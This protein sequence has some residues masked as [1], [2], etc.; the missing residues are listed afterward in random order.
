MARA[1]LSVPARTA[2]ADRIF[3]GRSVLDYGCGRGG[4]VRRLAAEQLDVR[5]WDPH[6]QPDPP[7]TLADVVLLSYVLNV[8]D[9][10][11]ERVRTLAAAWELARVCLVVA[12]RTHHDARKLRGIA[13]RDGLLTSRGTFQILSHPETFAIWAQQIVPVRAVTARPG[14]LYLFRTNEARAHYLAHR[15]AAIPDLSGGTDTL[16]DLA[17]WLGHHGRPPKDDEAP[18]LVRRVERQ[19]GTMTRGAKAAGG[20]LGPDDLKLAQK[21]RKTDLLVVLAMDAFHGRSQFSDLPPTL[22]HDARFH[23]GTY[24]DATHRA[25]QLLAALS[26]PEFIRKATH[27]SRLGKVTPTALYVHTDCEPSLSAA[28]RVY[29]ACAELVA[30]RPP[31]TNILKLHH[32]RAAVSFLEYP[33]F[34]TDGHPKLA[35]SMLVNLAQMKVDRRDYTASVNRPILHRKEEFLPSQHPRRDLYARLTRREVAAG[36]YAQPHLI[37]TEDGWSKVL[38]AAGLRLTGHRLL[39][40][41]HEPQSTMSK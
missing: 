33:D 28:L 26:R 34:D 37:G 10:P 3:D 14:Q 6:Y 8:I 38:A 22:R 11:A 25:D 27:A 36:L 12:V 30:G 41:V 35:T 39:K 5:G 15:Y 7:P 13:H 19:F 24:R 32:D 4:D 2:L 17:A 21:R 40:A 29:I 18:D 23:F 9:D 31:Q 1:G 16:T 20:L